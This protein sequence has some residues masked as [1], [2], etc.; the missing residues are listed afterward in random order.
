M[1]TSHFLCNLKNEEEQEE[2]EEEEDEE[3]AVIVSDTGE[4]EFSKGSKD[5]VRYAFNTKSTKTVQDVTEAM[6]SMK[7]PLSFRNV[8][9]S[10]RRYDGKDGYPISK[11]LEDFEKMSMLMNWTDLQKLIFAKKIVRWSG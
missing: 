9:D 11:W 5:G 8:E 1:G 10:I 4:D 6:R 2:E 7:F 3:K